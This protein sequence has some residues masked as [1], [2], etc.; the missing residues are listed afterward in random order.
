MA[1]N[2]S[3]S[4]FRKIDVD[5]Y[6]EDNFREDDG[7]DSAAVG[8]D[9]TE[10]T[11][12]LTQ[13]KVV[14]ALLSALQNAPLRCKNQIVKDHALNITL[15]VL[16][17][18]KSTQIDQAIDTVD[19]NDL[20]DVL[21]KYIYRGFEIPSEGSSGHLLQWHEKAFAKGGVGCIVRVLSDTNRA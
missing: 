19:Q 3:S 18:I 17:S 16:L 12:L 4:A 13:G 9:E 21:M 1:K 6:N 8:P 10:I 14:E 15:R 11:T 2:T 5:Q 20:I 7:V